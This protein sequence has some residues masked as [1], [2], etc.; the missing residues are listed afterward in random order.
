M[1]SK[2]LV[3]LF[4]SI[5]TLFT[6]ASFYCYAKSSGV[7]VSFSAFD[8]SVIMPKEEIT[9][10]DGIAEEYGYANLEKDHNGESIN[11]ITA[12][13]V[14]TAAHKTY[15][16]DKF[17]KETSSEYLA[18][19]DGQIKLAFGKNALSSGFAVNNKSP[20]DDI[21]LE[22]P[23]WGSSY[24]GYSISEARIEDGDYMAYFF[25]QDKDFY[26]D[27][28][29]WFTFENETFNYARVKKGNSLTLTLNG[30][31]IAWYGCYKEEDQ[32]ITSLSGVDVYLVENN[33]YT[34]LGKTD[35][36][37]QITVKFDKKGDFKIVAYGET[38]DESE[39]ETPVCASWGQVK[40]QNGLTYF[41]G[42]IIEFFRKII[43]A[44]GNLFK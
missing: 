27:M 42:N 34:P 39:M 10:N 3:S 8:G 13:D 37:G 31:S 28:Y 7:T 16:G 24:T 6:S 20:H 44:I 12:L 19:E 21:Y 1:N 29:S 41:F 25:Y 30:F 23:T 32:N 11:G 4:L 35:E 18:V 38:L 9:V 17:T 5:L 22:D 15:Y 2:K 14:L 36:K 43:T 33:E 40:V 26:S